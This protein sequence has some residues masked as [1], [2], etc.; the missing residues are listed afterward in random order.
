[1]SDKQELFLGTNY[2][3]SA[4]D[5]LGPITPEDEYELERRAYERGLMDGWDAACD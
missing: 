1:M 5:G 4:D 3:A 2:D